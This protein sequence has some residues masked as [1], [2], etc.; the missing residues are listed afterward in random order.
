MAWL[1]K[2]PEEALWA[3]L[4]S[5]GGVWRGRQRGSGAEGLVSP[6]A[7]RVVPTHVWESKEDGIWSTG[8]HIPA[9]SSPALD[10]TEEGIVSCLGEAA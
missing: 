6:E 7:G 3:T 1:L 8:G 2:G 9:S 10:S 4:E 5:W